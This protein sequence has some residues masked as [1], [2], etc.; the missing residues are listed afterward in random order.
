MANEM[1]EPVSL[2]TGPGRVL[3]VGGINQASARG[4]AQ[5][6]SVGS[7]A[8][9]LYSKAAA[10]F[11]QVANEIG[12][13]ADKAA[14]R[15]GHEAGLMAGADSEFRLRGDGTIYSQAFD[16][17]GLETFKSK[18]SVDL[19]TQMEAAAEKFQAD[20]EGLTAALG[21]VRKGWLSGIDKSLAPHVLPDLDSQFNRQQIGLVRD[22][23]REFHAR[24][25]SEQMGA[26]EA[27]R[28]LRARTAEQQAYRLGLDGTADQVL[29]GEL[30]DYKTR[31]AVRGPDGQYLVSPKEQQQQLRAAEVGIARARIGGS[32]ARLPDLAS[33]QR[34]IEDLGARYQAGGDHV[35]DLFDPGEFH[36]LQATLMSEARR[37]GFG[38]EQAVRAL[39]EDV[40]AFREAAKSGLALR[41]DEMSG[42]K[43]S[44]AGSGDPEL[45]DAFNAGLE[46]FAI[47]RHLNTM[48]PSDIEAAI[49]NEE[50]KARASGVSIAG[51]DLERI[52][53]MRGYLDKAK[54]AL[55]TDQLGFAARTGTIS[56]QPL[57]WGNPAS[58]RARVAAAEQA[59][60]VMKRAPQYFQPQ[61]RDDIAAV[62][63]QGGDG[64][65][66]VAGSIVGGFGRDH[67]EAAIT[68]VAKE[69]PVLSVVG[70][71]W[72]QSRSSEPPPVARDVAKGV[73]LR[74]L[75]G[76]KPLVDKPSVP[77]VAEDVL[78]T[79]FLDR[80]A[81]REAILDA[82]GAAYEARAY[83]KG[84]TVF[85][86]AI[87][88]Q[89]LREVVGEREIGG[90]T[91]GGIIS[92]SSFAIRTGPS[93]TLLPSIKQDG[94][95]DV[96]SMVD[97]G[98]LDRAG[99]PRPVGRDGQPISMARLK[100]GTLIE[101]EPGRYHI[102][103]GKWDVV[104]QEEYVLDASGK[105]FVFDVEALVPVLS[106]RR[107]DLFSGGR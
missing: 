11:G 74:A 47:V 61:E 35:L 72:R 43:A 67:A 64:L 69:A 70:N 48:A 62:S 107:P 90:E 39:K 86:P 87:Y 49:A 52:D 37:E 98:D 54:T 80:P 25:R 40:K 41:D 59:A 7:G 66:A 82:A 13:I 58:V 45:Q 79:A 57:D 51:R 33:R 10:V 19:M 34:F 75:K 26:L 84:V 38:G 97:A 76:Y 17:A 73:E 30:A 36:A 89:S 95:G 28:E 12:Q 46:D 21:A 27:D 18:A 65:L 92:P 20:P 77:G 101:Q 14:Q 2:P 93:I 81:Y 60:A 91:F 5:A 4:V 31:L 106:K 88:E 94:W 83:A 29:A 32:F 96:I 78:G 102:A 63:R 9:E 99:L 3:P 104:G 100:R 22:A 1:R 42:I 103:L 105:P 6:A 15:E 16:Q 53:L 68:E 8:V 44:V 55:A 85:D 24:V 50:Q 23:T 71:L 56:L